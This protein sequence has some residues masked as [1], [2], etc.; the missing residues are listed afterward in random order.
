MT[1]AQRFVH[2]LVMRCVAGVVYIITVIVVA[3]IVITTIFTIAIGIVS[4]QTDGEFYIERL[5]GP[6]RLISDT[7]SLVIPGVTTLEGSIPIDGKFSWYLEGGERNTPLS[8]EEYVEWQGI[9]SRT[10]KSDQGWEKA[11]LFFDYQGE[12]GNSVVFNVLRKMPHPICKNGYACAISMKGKCEVYF[13]PDVN[14]QDPYVRVAIEHEVGHCLF[15]PGH[16]SNYNDIMYG[17]R[18]SQVISLNEIAVVQKHIS[19]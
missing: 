7:A 16:S 15:G 1:L 10:L 19:R 12:G 4:A 13:R 8:S 9:I 17:A 6:V 2:E 11:G 14:P 18:G 3:M 5:P